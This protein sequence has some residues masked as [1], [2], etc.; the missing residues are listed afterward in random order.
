MKV[1][2]GEGDPVQLAEKRTTTFN[3]RKIF[4]SSTPT[5]KYHSRIEKAF[6]ESDKRYFWVE[7]VHCK[8]EQKLVWEQVKWTGNDYGKA[9]YHCIHC[10]KPWTDLQRWNSL[11]KGKWIAET[12]FT[13]K[14]G[15]H[16]SELYSPWVKISTIVMKYLESKRGGNTQLRVWWN[17][18]LGLPY[19]ENLEQTPVNQL[20][21]RTEDFSIDRIP[22]E[23]IYITLGGDTQDDRIEISIL[24]WGLKQE[25]YVLGHLKI[26]GNTNQSDPWNKLEEIIDKEFFKKDGNIIKIGARMY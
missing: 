24:G 1:R 14:A 17:T 9:R 6:N 8:K 4:L 2:V 19:E 12:P 20:L 26:P 16:I 11:K 22:N 10:D 13:G 23:V 15:F 18:C 21:K 25:C 5:E 7:C 3:N